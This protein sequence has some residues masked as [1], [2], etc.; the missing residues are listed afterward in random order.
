MASPILAPNLTISTT[1]LGE[2]VRR[3]INKDVWRTMY[4]RGAV[5]DP[6]C[7]PV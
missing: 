7:D 5:C 2:D 4:S 6:V 1:S 3:R